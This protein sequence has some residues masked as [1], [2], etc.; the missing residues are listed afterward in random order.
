MTLLIVGASNYFHNRE[1]DYLRAL[2]DSRGFLRYSY[3]ATR[4]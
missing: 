2:N 3:C 4:A 1:K